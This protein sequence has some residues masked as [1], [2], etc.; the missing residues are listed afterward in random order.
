M[1]INRWFGRRSEPLVFNF[2]KGAVAIALLTPAP[3]PFACAPNLAK[4]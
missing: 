2:L 1:V 4:I 3:R